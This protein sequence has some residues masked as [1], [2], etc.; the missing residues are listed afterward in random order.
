MTGQVTRVV[1]LLALLCCFAGNKGAKR[2]GEKENGGGVLEGKLFG[3]EVGRVKGRVPYWAGLARGRE[4]ENDKGK[5][6]WQY[7]DRNL[8]KRWSLRGKEKGI[9]KPLCC[10]RFTQKTPF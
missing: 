5:N 2:G 6:E 1:G 3:E 8:R 7:K 10:L 9:G 4:D